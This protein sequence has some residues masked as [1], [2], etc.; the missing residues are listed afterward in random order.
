MRKGMYGKGQ[1]KV[2]APLPD[3]CPFPLLPEFAHAPAHAL[4]LRYVAVI[5]GSSSISACLS[6][7]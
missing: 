6:M 3:T 5:G 2:R 1:G 7:T 4:F